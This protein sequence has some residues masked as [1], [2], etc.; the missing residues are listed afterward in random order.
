MKNKKLVSKIIDGI[1]NFLIVIFAIFLL[2]S[3]YTAIQVKVFG[4]D[5]S[6]F[7]GYSLFEVQTGSMSGTIEPGDHKL[8]KAI[9]TPKYLLSQYEGDIQVKIHW[10]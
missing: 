3:M 4:N 5:Y 7:F 10:N 2:I 6:S 1:L 9:L 8:I